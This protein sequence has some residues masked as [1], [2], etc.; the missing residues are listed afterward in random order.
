MKY[1]LTLAILLTTAVLLYA[2]AGP[3]AVKVT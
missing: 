3:G 2:A 1:L